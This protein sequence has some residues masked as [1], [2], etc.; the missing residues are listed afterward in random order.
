MNAA[1]LGAAADENL[2]R[3]WAALGRAMGADVVDDGPL[4]LVATGIPIAFFNGAYLNE[5]AG[6]PDA[7]IAQAIEFFAARDLAWLLWVR[8][9]VAPN[10]LE[11]GRAAGLHDVGGPPAMGVA[12]I[13]Q[14]P[15]APPELTIEIATTAAQLADH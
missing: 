1:E 14:S 6:D 12:P 5:A 3:T 13:P 4:T 9:G 7:M 10:V 15:P 2:A 8:E 11:R